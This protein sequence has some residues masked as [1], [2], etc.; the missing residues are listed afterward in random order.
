[1]FASGVLRAADA[2]ALRRLLN[3]R[4]S[5]SPREYAAAAEVVARDAA[6]GHPLQQY[7]MAVFSKDRA[8]PSSVR[9]T[10]EQRAKYLESSKD[11]IAA[12][13]HK[14]NNPL[15]WYLL[16]LESN[17]RTLLRRAVEG[18]NV[19]ALNA[20]GTILL[21]ETIN[22]GGLDTNGVWRLMKRG[23]ECFEKAAAQKDANGLY[24]FGMC[25]LNGYGCERDPEKALEY[26]KAA[27]L[28]D[29]PEAINNIGGFY[30]DGIVVEKD[31][32]LATRHFS[33]SAELGNTYGELNFGLALQRGE[34]IAQD[35]ARAFGLFKDAASKG[36]PEA[37]NA[38]GMCFFTGS[39]TE[40]NEA[41]AVLW[42][43][44]SS[45][46][47]CPPAMENMAVCHERGV[48]GL[49]KSVS[50]GTVYKMRAR[51]AQGDRN[52]AAW[53]AQNGHSLR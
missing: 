24:N 45:A 22:S 25:L 48:G 28:S 15:A 23:Y 46:L 41:A 36:N 13:A 40:K 34:G 42:F 11:R 37:M 35:E 18:G 32:F 1:M 7:V 33:R 21:N 53:L 50:M 26:F 20:W 2:E 52:A 51:A 3:T 8:M 10:D 17:D 5:G 47:G 29:H 4:S 43:R 27:A 6:A 9:L 19:Q 31:D 14:K 16:S 12:L 30:R 49:E 38:L 39:G 44:R